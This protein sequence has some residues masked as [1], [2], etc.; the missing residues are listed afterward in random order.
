MPTEVSKTN[1]ASPRKVRQAESNTHSAPKQPV[2]KKESPSSKNTKKAASAQES[3][4]EVSRSP[5]QSDTETDSVSHVRKRPPSAN[6]EPP[7]Q[8]LSSSS[9]Y[10]NTNAGNA[11]P[12]LTGSTPP[13]APPPSSGELSHAQS[14]LTKFGQLNPSEIKG[15]SS[16]QDFANA[17][18]NQGVGQVTSGQITIDD[19]NKNVAGVE[20]ANLFD[21]D[22]QASFRT[23]RLAHYQKTFSAADAATKADRDL[24]QAKQLLMAGKGNVTPI[25]LLDTYNQLDEYKFSIKELNLK[26]KKFADIDREL[27]QF[28]VAK[29][30]ANPT[31][32]ANAE[33]I[34]LRNVFF[35]QD[36]HQA[37]ETLKEAFA[38]LHNANSLT[39]EQRQRIESL[40]LD[41]KEI[42]EVMADGGTHLTPEQVMKNI[43][44]LPQVDFQKYKELY[45]NSPALSS[46]N[47][48]V[49]ELAAEAA[50]FGLQGD[51]LKAEDRE[52]A[53]IDAQSEVKRREFINQNYATAFAGNEKAAYEYMLEQGLQVGM[54]QT[55]AERYAKG[56]SK[57]F[58][59]E[60]LS[61][62]PGTFTV[63]EGP[64]AQVFN[65]ANTIS[66]FPSPQADMQGFNRSASE[67]AARLDPSAKISVKDQ[68]GHTIETVSVDA[69]RN[70]YLVPNYN[71]TYLE[72][73]MRP[74]SMWTLEGMGE[75]A[76]KFDRW[77]G[78]AVDGWLKSVDEA[79]GGRLH[80]IGLWFG[81][82]MALGRNSQNPVISTLAKAERAL[83]LFTLPQIGSNILHGQKARAGTTTFIDL[84]VTALSWIGIGFFG[85]MLRAGRYA[86]QN[87]MAHEKTVD[88]MNPDE[89]VTRAGPK[90]EEPRIKQTPSVE[91]EA[92]KLVNPFL[93]EKGRNLLTVLKEMRHPRRF[94]EHFSD[95]S[96]TKGPFLFSLGQNLGNGAA[97]GR[98]LAKE[99]QKGRQLSTSERIDEVLKPQEVKPTSFNL[100]RDQSVSS[101]DQFD[102]LLDKYGNPVSKNGIYIDPKTNK[103]LTKA[104]SVDPKTHK[105]IVNPDDTLVDPET[106]K[107]AGR[108]FEGTVID[109]KSGMH[110]SKN[111]HLLDPKSAEYARDKG[112]LLDANSGYVVR[113]VEGSSPVRYQFVH[114]DNVH[115][116]DRFHRVIGD[117]G[118]YMI[119]DPKTKKVVPVPPLHEIDGA[120]RLI[121]VVGDDG[122]RLA[123][124]EVVQNTRFL[125]GIP[126]TDTVRTAPVLMSNNLRGAVKGVPNGP[127]AKVVDAFLAFRD[128]VREFGIIR[129]PVNTLAY[130]YGIGVGVDLGFQTAFAAPKMYENI[131]NHKSPFDGVEMDWARAFLISG[132]AS[133]FWSLLSRNIMV[134]ATQA[135]PDLVQ[136]RMNSSLPFLAR[137]YTILKNRLQ[138]DGKLNDDEAQAYAL[139]TKVLSIDDSFLRATQNP[140]RHGKFE[141]DDGAAARN[142]QNALM[143]I[144]NGPP[145]SLLSK[146]YATAKDPVGSYI[147]DLV[148][149]RA[150]LAGKANIGPEERAVLSDADSAI[151]A[152]TDMRQ[153]SGIHD[154]LT[155]AKGVQA[156]AFHGGSLFKYK[157][158][159]ALNKPE[160]LMRETGL[161][162][163]FWAPFALSS[164]GVNDPSG[165]FGKGHD[166]H[167]LWLSMQGLGIGGVRY[168]G[169][170]FAAFPNGLTGKF[171][172]QLKKY[173]NRADIM[174]G[175]PMGTKG[176]LL[177]RA[178]RHSVQP[179]TALAQRVHQVP[180]PGNFRDRAAFLE[181]RKKFDASH[182]ILNFLHYVYW[183][184]F[185]IQ[186]LEAMARVV[187]RGYLNSHIVPR[188]TAVA[189]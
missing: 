7:H 137:S 34:R 185:Q 89:L 88:A 15:Y 144:A 155:G 170:Q 111:G 37:T 5:P 69:F 14:T 9:L 175:V 2:K 70:K 8:D 44:L 30:E 78:P 77:F 125:K 98:I 151:K 81:K 174:F 135:V 53:L 187:Q 112:L 153:V 184:N 25:K 97:A 31:E 99:T 120:G 59:A 76:A 127:M 183:A 17:T 116:L 102:R 64:N 117:D 143:K 154:V 83:E 141:G 66:G 42:V 121:R 71:Q 24:A 51:L 119:V 1:S 181:A 136:T 149:A 157:N 75:G 45:V 63:G 182:K 156:L 23:S 107:A 36:H 10:P 65:Y 176:N 92:P 11:S 146:K 33:A 12:S 166:I 6:A 160:Q 171:Q 163:G 74:S 72:N 3:R 128:K 57:E 94:M 114:S 50:V 67:F 173:A 73:V 29:G 177:Q 87:S 56:H 86:S 126:L 106:I 46:E 16:P 49:R 186:A 179:L 61:Q 108:G 21:D 4:S 79:T 82:T 28:A 142:V 145:H 43:D 134:S 162:S 18:V 172:E 169:T 54:S 122:Y 168:G 123:Q 80:P 68:V 19:F 62:T 22:F 152:L 104:S 130:S 105:P 100:T 129:R 26:D 35:T 84:G 13:V 48:T 93:Q 131:V 95:W 132:P 150:A 20:Q 165:N 91:P 110:V 178:Y 113:A 118:R 138:K 96:A 39:L 147:D 40:N 167:S 47:P 103:L 188:V 189:H 38:G 41:S 115:L 58:L 164:F 101:V 161:Q 55:L 139:L 180:H 109:A 90:I 159:I 27:N 124:P 158:R 140:L 85:R 60:T 148:A 32:F 133:M 52:K